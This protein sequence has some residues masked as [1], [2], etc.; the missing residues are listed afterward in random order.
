MALAEKYIGG[1]KCDVV[2]YD[3]TNQ[4]SECDTD[5]PS[6]IATSEWLVVTFF[7]TRNGL[8]SSKV[9]HVPF[10]QERANFLAQGL[11]SKFMQAACSRPIIPQTANL[12]KSKNSYYWQKI[13]KTSNQWHSEKLKKR[14]GGV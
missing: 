11:H 14:G 13:V 12:S 5:K 7:W 10:G 1:A 2:I 8:M 3:I 4:I 9:V 6:N